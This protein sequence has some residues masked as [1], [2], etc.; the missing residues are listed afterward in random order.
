MT[1]DLAFQEHEQLIRAAAREPECV[2]VPRLSYL[3][4]DGRGDPGTTP[5]YGVALGALFAVSYAVKFRLRSEGVDYKVAPPES[6]WWAESMTAFSSGDAADRSSW[7]WTAMI[8]QPAVATPELVKRTA[9]AV[10]AKK[11]D[12]AGLDRLRLAELAEGQAVQVLHVGPWSEEGPVIAGLHAYAH[13]LGLT[14]DGQVH[15]H[16]EIYL[17]DS[18]RVPPERWRTVVRQPVVP[19]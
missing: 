6:L 14:F 4:V 2:E 19:A 5:D 17:S 18:R 10:A 3:M 15:K 7:Q 13:A 12:V 11:K 8:A 16:H 1:S 9:D